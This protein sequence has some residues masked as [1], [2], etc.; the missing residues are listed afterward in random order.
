MKSGASIVFSAG[1]ASEASKKC[2]DALKRMG[3]SIK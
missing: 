2:E 3:V 1:F